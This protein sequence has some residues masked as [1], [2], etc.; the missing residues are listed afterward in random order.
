[1]DSEAKQQ[2]E[3]LQDNEEGQE[4]ADQNAIMNGT[5]NGIKQLQEFIHSS[6][7]QCCTSYPAAAPSHSWIVLTGFY[8]K[9]KNPSGLTL[10]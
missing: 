2:E 7:H 10:M 5:M 3:D 8:P 6:N 4:I 9:F 1:M